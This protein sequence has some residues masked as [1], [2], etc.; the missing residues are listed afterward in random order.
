MNLQTFK[1]II[2]LF[3]K[4]NVEPERL[5][6]F[7]NKAILEQF[8]KCYM[9]KDFES[10]RPFSVL[11]DGGTLPMILFNNGRAALPDDYF[12][13]PTMLTDYNEKVN[14]VDDDKQFDELLSHKIEFPTA[15]YPIANIQS[16]FIRLKPDTIRYCIFSYIAKP[17]PVQFGYVTTRGYVE[18]APS[19]SVELAWNET[20]IIQIIMLVLRDFGVLASKEEVKSKIKQ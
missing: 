2:G 17:T 7:T 16:N 13:N 9:G 18:Y 12:G 10:L 15:K 1:N 3:V 8:L 19:L 6:D 4:G 11:R 5:T 20:N 14:I